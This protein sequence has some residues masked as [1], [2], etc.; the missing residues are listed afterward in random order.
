[1]GFSEAAASD[2]LDSEMLVTSSAIPLSEGE[3]SVEFGLTYTN[4]KDGK[5][6]YYRGDWGRTRRGQ[7]AGRPA[8]DGSLFIY[9]WRLE[10]A[11]GVAPE[12]EVGISTGYVDIYDR[13][14]RGREGALIHVG[15][16]DREFHKGFYGGAHSR[17]MD[18][19]TIYAKRR[20]LE[21]GGTSVALI[22]G[23]TI[24]TGR[25]SKVSAGSLE[26]GRARL[27]AGQNFWS[28]EPKLALTQKMD[29]FVLNADIG[30]MVP[31]GRTRRA[32]MK[33]FGEHTSLRRRGDKD[34]ILVYQKRKEYGVMDINIGAVYD[35]GPVRP[36]V[37]LNYAHR[38]V[39]GGSGSN[40]VHA[41]IGSVITIG[42]DLPRIKVGYQHPVTGS[43]AARTRR[44]LLSTAYN[45]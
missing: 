4:A 17:G 9:E 12:T 21:D 6:G 24:P 29:E 25:E 33:D 40:I 35:E 30:Y 19:L 37:E 44:F 11:M 7:L 27:G 22:T 28:L 18:D 5:R 43:N 13:M 23:L 41:M 32:Y 20:L 10:A 36:L 31:F 34:E 2:Y 16:D 8:Y 39:S 45:F 42:E 38:V 1:M 3:T 15:G 26:S 14:H